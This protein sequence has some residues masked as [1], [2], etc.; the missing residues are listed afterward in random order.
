ML[1]KNF[2]NNFLLLF[3]GYFKLNYNHFI[4]INKIIFH[5]FLL[6]LE[7]HLVL[8]KVIIYDSLCNLHDHLS[9]LIFNL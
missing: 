4:I 2:L 6:Y 1:F 3:W 8:L 5:Y 7:D 9:R